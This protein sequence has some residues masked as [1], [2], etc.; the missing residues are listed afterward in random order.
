MLT[1]Y[2][3]TRLT[4]S[5]EPVS[6]EVVSRVPLDDEGHY[7]TRYETGVVEVPLGDYY[8]IISDVDSS[9]P[10]EPPLK[11]SVVNGGEQPPGTLVIE[12]PS[13]TAVAIQAGRSQHG[14]DHSPDIS[15]KGQ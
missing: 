3:T 8:A 14:H 11:L 10:L 9:K 6:G 2:T 1:I 5:K 7:Y 4:L 12:M 15:E 13:G